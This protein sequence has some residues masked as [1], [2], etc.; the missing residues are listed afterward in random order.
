M[1]SF[2]TFL[3]SLFLFLEVVWL[4]QGGFVVRYAVRLGIQTK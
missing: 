4:V 3:S 1:V 2:G